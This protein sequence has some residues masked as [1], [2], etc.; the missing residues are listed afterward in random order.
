MTGIELNPP[1]L[2]EAINAK[3]FTGAAGVRIVAISPFK[4]GWEKSKSGGWYFLL[5]SSTAR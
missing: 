5:M 2:A 3:G 1:D 4:S